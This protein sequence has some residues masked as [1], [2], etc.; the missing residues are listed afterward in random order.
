[1]ED[2]S[3]LAEKY[4]NT[5]VTISSEI[6]GNLIVGS[7]FITSYK[8]KL[9][10]ITSAHVVFG[11]DTK[12]PATKIICGIYNVNGEPK[13]NLSYEL[14]IIGVDGFAD[15]AILWIKD[16]HTYKEI[17]SYKCHPHFKIGNNLSEK[18]GIRI[19]NISNPLGKD[20]G[21]VVSGNLRD[22]KY[23]SPNQ[24]LKA[25]SITTSC[26]VYPSSSGSCVINN[27]GRVLGLISFGFIQQGNVQTAA[28]AGGTGAYTLKI[29]IKNIM[30]GNNVQKIDYY[31]SNLKGWFGDITYNT[32]TARFLNLLYPN[33]F[34]NLK[35]RGLILDEITEESPLTKPLK[36]KALKRYDIIVAIW[37]P[38][39]EKYLEIGPSEDQYPPGIALWRY[40]PLKNN[41]VKLKVIY[42]PKSNSKVEEISVKLDLIPN[43]ELIPT[44]GRS[45]SNNNGMFDVNT[46]QIS[47]CAY[48]ISYFSKNINVIMDFSPQTKFIVDNLP[49][50]SSGGF[51]FSDLWYMIPIF[52]LTDLKSNKN[53][54]INGTIDISNT[55][56]SEVGKSNIRV[57]F[58][59]IV[60]F[61]HTI[62][63]YYFE[64]KLT[65][66]IYKAFDRKYKPDVFLFPYNAIIK[67]IEKNV[68]TWEAE[69]KKIIGGKEYT[70]I[71]TTAY[72]EGMTLR[73]IY[74]SDY[75]TTDFNKPI[76]S[77]ITFEIPIVIS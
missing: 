25:G 30:S 34:K 2:S 7:G 51:F 1:M 43:P 36:G 42:D 49:P 13:N 4:S 64:M 27:K 35:I 65:F 29:I 46:F 40:N 68:I 59:S 74:Y 17:P 23:N 32:V 63:L 73:I 11:I 21:S 45:L 37:D 12:T 15:C 9:I 3:A 10:I 24:E 53:D 47:S 57:F 50:T 67:V 72:S 31:L 38:T 22:N 54:A 77:E 41:I 5:T 28:F 8:K 70:F 69:E 75:G 44:F 48:Y 58:P 26:P 55:D 76:A 56:G 14:K 66:P 39:T 16:E 6:S 71:P 20:V 18:N 60:A 52:K 33:N 61:F 62:N 19:T